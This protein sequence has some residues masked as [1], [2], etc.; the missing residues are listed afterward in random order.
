[1]V[2]EHSIVVT[3]GKKYRYSKKKLNPCYVEMCCSQGSYCNGF[4]S[5]NKKIKELKEKSE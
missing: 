4:T 1:M 5:E 2:A 3:E